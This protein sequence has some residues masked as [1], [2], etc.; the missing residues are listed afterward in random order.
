MNID[1]STAPSWARYAAMDS[2]GNW[3]WYELKPK[4]IFGEWVEGSDEGRIERI[5]DINPVWTQTLQERPE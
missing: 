3:Y 2:D 4:P 5:N 1:W